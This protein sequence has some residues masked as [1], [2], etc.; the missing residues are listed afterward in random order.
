M[1][2]NTLKTIGEGGAHAH[3]ILPTKIQTK[4]DGKHKHIFFINDRLIMTELDGEHAHSVDIERNQIGPESPKHVHNIHSFITEKSDSHLHEIQSGITTLSGVHR[5]ILEVEDASYISVIPSDMLQELMLKMNIKSE[6]PFETDFN[7]LKRLNKKINLDRVKNAVEKS[8]IKRMTTLGEGLR[9][10]SLILSKERFTDVGVATR[11]VLDQGLDIKSSA[12]LTEQGVFTFQIMSRDAFE[13]TTLQR[14]RITEGVEAVIGFLAEKEEPATPNT[15]TSGTINEMTDVQQENSNDEN[16]K[17][18]KNKFKNT[19]GNYGVDEKSTT[20]KKSALVNW[21][22]DKVITGTL[23]EL[24]SNISKQFNIERK[25]VTVEYPRKSLIKLVED[26]FE[27]EHAIYSDLGENYKSVVSSY[28]KNETMD[29]VTVQ[30]GCND[31]MI[32][33]FDDEEEMVKFLNDNNVAD[34]E[35][36]VYTVK[37]TM[38]G[39]TLLPVSL[40]KEDKPILDSDILENLKVDTETFFEKRDFYLENNIKHKRGIFMIGPPGNGKTTFLKSYLHE[41][42]SKNRFG[43]MV[44]CSKRFDT[45]IQKFLETVIKDNEKIIVLEDMDSIAESDYQ[46]AGL[47]NFIDGVGSMDKTL[48]IATSNHP[49]KLDEAILKRP[50]RFDKKYLIDLPSLEMRKEFIKKYFPDLTADELKNYAEKTEGF[51]GAY[52]KELFLLKNLQEITIME[53]IEKLHEQIN[54]V[55][56]SKKKNTLKSLEVMLFEKKDSMENYGVDKL[57]KSIKL[58]FEIVSKNMEERLVIGPVLIPENVDL[59]DDII[60]PDEIKKSAHGYMIKLAFRDDVEFLMELGFRSARSERGFQHIE[61][62]RKIA[63]VETFLAPVDFELNGRKITK[64]TWVMT[65]KVFDDE[66]WNMVKLG[67]ITGFSIGGRSKTKPEDIQD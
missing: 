33:F 25:F 43:I 47:L 42:V 16:M 26:T 49:G 22:T 24:I 63:V 13:E 41:C 10:E 12:V 21:S 50:S 3:K 31:S 19:M 48:F 11:F 52:F 64:G 4:K 18:L 17:N 60:S 57:E 2:K 58:G 46:R 45:D 20:I 54:M 62:N 5:H 23:Q 35:P 6:I 9:I 59:Q 29:V 36:G 34:Y 28:A 14:I 7:L 56:K 44:D 51:S 53:A 1:A 67:K 65:V 15:V 39:Y 30:T 61:F 37:E 32:F 8:I 66:V 55:Y 27:I 38:F 40:E